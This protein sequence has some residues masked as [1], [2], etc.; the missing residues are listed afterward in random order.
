MRVQSEERILTGYHTWSN[1]HRWARIPEAWT[2]MFS[3]STIMSSNYYSSQLTTDLWESGD[4]KEVYLCDDLE[5]AGPSRRTC[6]DPGL[7]SQARR[8][9]PSVVGG[10]QYFICTAWFHGGGGGDCSGVNIDN[11]RTFIFWKT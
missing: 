10:G 3:A 9:V 2:G 1:V 8:I 6:W 4:R 5:V 11:C 7:T